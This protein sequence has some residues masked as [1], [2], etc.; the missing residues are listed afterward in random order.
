[1]CGD[2]NEKAIAWEGPGDH[3]ILWEKV[4]A[5]KGRWPGFLLPL[6]RFKRRLLTSAY[7]QTTVG[8]YHCAGRPFR[9]IPLIIST[10]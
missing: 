3:S 8:L 10:G 4:E 5:M 6:P 2:S 7:G 1:M 9:R